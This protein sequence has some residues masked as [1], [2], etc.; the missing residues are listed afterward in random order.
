MTDQNRQPRQHAIQTV[1]RRSEPSADKR[2]DAARIGTRDRSPHLD[3]KTVGPHHPDGFRCLAQSFSNVGQQQFL[4]GE[5]DT[6]ARGQFALHARRANGGYTCRAFRFS[7]LLDRIAAGSRKFQ[8]QQ[9]RLLG[10]SK[11]LGDRIAIGQA[12]QTLL[13]CDFS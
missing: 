10:G 11:R 7:R 3:I 13:R 1:G 6:H 9:P 8:S 4:T 5:T 12:D 2:R